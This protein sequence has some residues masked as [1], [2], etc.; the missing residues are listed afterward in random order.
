MRKYLSKMIKLRKQEK[1]NAVIAEIKVHSPKHGDLLGGR[2]IQDILRTYERCDVAGISYITERDHFRGDFRTF[3]EI[4]RNTDLP[5]LRKDFVTSVDEVER[6]AEAEGSAL[7][8]IAGL[9]GE[10]T[11]EL[12]D[13]C[14]DHGIEA[15]V[16]VHSPED[17]ELANEVSAKLVGINNRDISKLELDDGSVEVTERLAPLLK[18]PALKVSES[19][20]FTLD[21]LSRALKHADAVLVGT[22]FMV[23]E[24]ME[25][26]VRQFVR[27]VEDA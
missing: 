25:G 20:I 10:R 18:S 23:A 19:G 8:L 11:A 15:L 22:A 26:K 4:C 1:L 24:N 6:T 9:L 2:K 16:E 27:G 14:N 5:V 13:A 21:H 7:L 17:V 3:R 12:V